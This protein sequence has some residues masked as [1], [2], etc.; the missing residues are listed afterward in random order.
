MTTDR[1]GLV[2]VLRAELDFLERGGYRNPSWRPRFIFED[3]PSCLNYNDPEHSRPCSECVLMK[4][5]PAEARNDRFPCRHIPLNDQGE[6]IDSLYRS[7]TQEEIESAVAHWL[8]EM[9][10]KLESAGEKVGEH[11]K[12]IA[13]SSR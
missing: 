7:A 5:V 12:S 1:R 2:D 11:T 4:L 6:T 10:K 3:S 8:R 13:S 9:I